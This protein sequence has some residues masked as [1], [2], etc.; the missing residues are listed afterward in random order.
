MNSK[1]LLLKTVFACMSC[2]G[3]IAPEEV[4]LVRELVAKT[5][6]FK[7][8]EVE[9]L[10]NNYIESINKNGVAFLNQY[11]SEVA[12]NKLTKEEQLC[13]VDLAIKTIEADNI[14]QYSEVKFFKKIRVRLPLT[15]EESL[16]KHPDKEDF[17]LPDIN[18][19]DFPEWNDVTFELIKLD[20]NPQS[21][22][23]QD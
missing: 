5:D 23:S 10:L 1:E 13:L 7:G 9:T 11:L 15:D 16:E 20:I 19:A 8:L 3:D 18:V 2:D 6:L 14:I 17:L 12:E 21:A 4:Q 22:P